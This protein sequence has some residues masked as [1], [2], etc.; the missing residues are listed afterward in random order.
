MPFTTVYQKVMNK[1]VSYIFV[2]SY[3]ILK[4]APLKSV[5]LSQAI[6]MFSQL[7]DQLSNYISVFENH[8]VD[9]EILKQ[10]IKDSLSEVILRLFVCTLL[11]CSVVLISISLSHM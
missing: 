7:Y 10:L 1:N 8:F 9:D 4:L 6:L 11:F 2:I 3:S 5:F